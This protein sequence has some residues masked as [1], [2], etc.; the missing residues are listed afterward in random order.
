MLELACELELP[1]RGA[2]WHLLRQGKLP[3]EFIK[4][5]KIDLHLI[6]LL[7]TWSLH[8][9]TSCRPLTL[10]YLPP[11][12]YDGSLSRSSPLGQPASPRELH[13]VGWIQAQTSLDMW[14]GGPCLQDGPQWGCVC[15]DGHC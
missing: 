1:S 6:H 2:N 15:T 3:H 10:F 8:L 4:G 7:L 12:S 5:N 13:S 9:P 14:A 11:D